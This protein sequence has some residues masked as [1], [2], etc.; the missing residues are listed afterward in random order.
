MTKKTDVLQ[1]FTARH[2]TYDRFIETVR[3]YERRKLKFAGEVRAG[4]TPRIRVHA[5]APASSE[6]PIRQFAVQ[7]EFAL[8]N[9]SYGR[10]NERDHVVRPKIVVQIRFVQWTAEGNMRHGAFV[11]TRADKMASTVV[12]E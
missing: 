7:Q 9:R 6:M 3:Y 10:G 5:E 4:M 12:R 8:G 11:R 2:G 1:L